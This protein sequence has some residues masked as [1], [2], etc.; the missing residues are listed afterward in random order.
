MTR[1]HSSLNRN[2]DDL[3]TR[4][5]DSRILSL[6]SSPRLSNSARAINWIL[7]FL[8]SALGTRRLANL[9]NRAIESPATSGSP[10]KLVRPGRTFMEL[11]PVPSMSGIRPSP[12][13]SKTRTRAP[14]GPALMKTPKKVDLGWANLAD[15]WIFWA[16]VKR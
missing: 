3:K 10:A 2:P 8:R 6:S 11:E 13:N 7:V 16:V 9:I 12:R 15:W 14:V 4:L 5:Q 1:A